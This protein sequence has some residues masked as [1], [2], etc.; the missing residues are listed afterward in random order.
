MT[1]PG[2][3]YLTLLGVI[4]NKV[5]FSKMVLVVIIPVMAVIL[6][7][8]GLFLNF[9]FNKEETWILVLNLSFISRLVF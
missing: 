7:M 8:L 1:S 4:L 5:Y 3:G 2:N 6:Q 9:F